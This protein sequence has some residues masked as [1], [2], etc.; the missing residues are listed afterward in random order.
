[1]RIETADWLLPF[2][3]RLLDRSATFLRSRGAER[4]DLLVAPVDPSTQA[5]AEVSVMYGQTDF[6]DGDYKARLTL[7]IGGPKVTCGLRTAL[8]IVEYVFDE[9]VHIQEVRNADFGRSAR[10]AAS[11]YG[12]EREDL[13]T[14]DV[15]DYAPGYHIA[16]QGRAWT[17]FFVQDRGHAS[18]IARSASAAVLP[19]MIH[20]YQER[21]RSELPDRA[22]KLYRG[23]SGSNT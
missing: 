11:A 1:M 8:E 13:L 17:L 5:G 23:F 6:D 7:G 3:K 19:Y 16:S 20:A 21:A 18:I 2:Y 10:D 4:Q 9:P 12:V 14:P 22:A 15:G